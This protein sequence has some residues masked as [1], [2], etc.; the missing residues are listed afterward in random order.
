MLIPFNQTIVRLQV[1]EAA[2][3]IVTYVR[4]CGT[5]WGVLTNGINWYFLEVTQ[6]CFRRFMGSLCCNIDLWYVQD[7]IQPSHLQVAITYRQYTDTDPGVCA[8]LYTL[9]VCGRSYIAET[10]AL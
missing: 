8:V 3:Q 9:H 4:A 2:T 7:A 1:V 10:S 6:A 5:R